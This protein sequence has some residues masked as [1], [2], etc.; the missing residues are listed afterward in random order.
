[1]NIKIRR[2]NLNIKKGKIIIIIIILNE[3]CVIWSKG[4]CKF[5]LRQKIKRR[6]D[7]AYPKRKQVGAL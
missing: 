4:R 7:K 1:M 3:R 2:K 6:K 5:R